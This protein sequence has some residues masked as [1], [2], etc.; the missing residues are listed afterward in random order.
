[1][2]LEGEAWVLIAVLFAGTYLAH[3]R[4]GVNVCGRKKDREGG[5]EERREEQREL[6]GEWRWLVLLLAHTVWMSVGGPYSPPVS[7]T[8]G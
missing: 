4:A 2:L 8:E 5:R 1:M 3:R 7:A 6:W